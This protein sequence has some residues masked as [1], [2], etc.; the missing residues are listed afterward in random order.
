MLKDIDTR[1]VMFPDCPVRNV[2]SRVGDK[3]SLLVLHTLT[4]TGAPVR[5]S[6]LRRAVPDISQK[7]LAATLR[8]LEEDGFVVRTVYA[9]VPPRV[10]YEA[11]ARARSFMQACRP[12][13]E[14]AVDN[15]AA[16]IRSREAGRAGR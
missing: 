14:W 16:I 9:E 5:F 11:T 10:E 1:D 2:L 3:W 12:M 15:L 8:R 13:L 4:A 6:A 7:M